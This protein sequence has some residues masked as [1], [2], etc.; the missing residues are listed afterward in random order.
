M[1]SPA[2][3]GSHTNTD[4]L[5]RQTDE[6]NRRGAFAFLGLAG[7]LQ[8]EDAGPTID[9]LIGQRMAN[10]DSVGSFAVW[11]VAASGSTACCIL[12]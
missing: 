8:N 3:T 6:G 10:A 12:Q 4:V 7:M 1:G 9:G 5:Q 11:T 2:K